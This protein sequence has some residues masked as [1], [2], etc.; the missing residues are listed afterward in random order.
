[1]SIPNFGL[2]NVTVIVDR[3]K[4]Q[5]DGATDDIM[6]LF[7]LD[8]KFKAFGFDVQTVNGHNVEAIADALLK[9]CN[10]PK[11]IIA[12]TIKANGISFLMNNKTSHHTSLVGKKYTQAIEDIK[13]AYGKL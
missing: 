7:S 6:N 1:M 2:D 12:D 3:N 8:D 5:L 13:H 10:M 9:D 4:Y 11:A